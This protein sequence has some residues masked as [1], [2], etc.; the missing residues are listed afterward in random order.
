MVRAPP[1]PPFFPKPIA[2]FCGRPLSP[3]PQTRY[4]RRAFNGTIWSPDGRPAY[5][6]C[7]PLQYAANFATPQFII[8][9][10]NDYRVPITEGIMMF[11]VL[12]TVGVPS[13][14]LTFPDENHWVLG[15][16]NSLYWH[17]EIFNWINYW[18]GKIPSLDGEAI[19][20]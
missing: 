10:E 16:E 18:T 2:T 12:Q 19:T 17:Q 9:S 11:N 15:R 1:P 20:Q 3:S 8:H 13:R 5:A 14:F 4:L 6:A 7:D